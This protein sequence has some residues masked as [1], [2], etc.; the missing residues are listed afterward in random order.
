MASDTLITI[1]TVFLFFGPVF[2]STT[3]GTTNNV[4][5][6]T[7]AKEPSQISITTYELL[8]I[9]PKLFRNELQPLVIHKNTMGMRT[10]LVTLPEVYHQMYWHGRDNAEK[11]KYFIKSAIEEWGVR[12]VLLVGGRSSQF[13]PNWFCPVRYVSMVDDWENEYLSDLYFADIYDA[14]GNFSSWDSDNDG[15]YGEWYPGE[16]AQDKEIDL[17]PDVAVGR[18]PCRSEKEVRTMV[19]KII[20][21]EKTVSDQPW[22]SAMLVAA[23]DTYP[24]TQNANWAGYE[25]EYYGDRAIENMSGFSATRLYTSDESFADKKDTPQTVQILFKDQTATIYGVFETKINSRFVLSVAVIIA[26]LTSV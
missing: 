2:T 26:S 22:F 14:H 12:Y 8:I 17:N 1:I 25:G 21:Y 10:K 23:G 20:T 9:T 18:L 19:Q 6:L 24:E 3:L 13:Q 7:S 16:T 4:H 5:F 11:V 15:I